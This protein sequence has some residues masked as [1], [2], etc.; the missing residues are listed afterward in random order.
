[1]AAFS[2][3]RETTADAPPAAVHA[4]LEDFHRWRDWSPWEERDPDLRRTFTGPER[5]VGA[6][7]EW[8]GNKTVFELLP[9]GTGTRVVWTMTGRRG[10]FMSVAGR[11][12]FDKVIAGDFDRGPAKLK[13]LVEG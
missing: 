13:A 8:E 1:M 9:A 11:L 3:S 4:V 6:H 12:F 2:L 10:L 7:Y 5:G